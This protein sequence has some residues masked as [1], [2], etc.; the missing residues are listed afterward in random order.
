MFKIDIIQ[1]QRGNLSMQVNHVTAYQS[2]FSGGATCVA[3]LPDGAKSKDKASSQV[4]P[5]IRTRGFIFEA[6]LRTFRWADLQKLI[7]P[8]SASEHF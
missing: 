6:L 7:P 5:T 8:L 1:G 4:F 2:L 3:F